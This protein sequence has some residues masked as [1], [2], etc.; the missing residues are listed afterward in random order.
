M[1]PES[2]RPAPDQ[3][4]ADGAERERPAADPPA[5]GRPVAPAPGARVRPGA[6]ARPGARTRPDA[7]AP[8][9]PRRRGPR[10]AFSLVA[11][12][13]LA[14]LAA[15]S[16]WA[17][18][19]LGAVDANDPRP[20]EFE[21]APGASAGRVAADLEAA[22]LLRDRRALLAVLRYRG[23]EGRIGEGLY[24]LRRDLTVPQI[25]D[26]LVRGG[27]PR[28]ARF[29]LPEGIRA[30]AV[31]RR[32]EAAGWTPDVVDG[33]AAIL[34]DPPPEWR[35]AGLPEGVGLEGYLFPAT[36]DLPLRM[37]AGEIVSAMLAR[38]QREVSGV[39][40]AELE[41]LEL[42][43][44][45]W[46]TLASMVQAEAGNDGEMG[47]IAGVFLNRLDLGMPLQSDPT[48]AY[49]L[50]KDLPELDRPAG[51]FETDHP[52]NTYTRPGLPVAPIGNPGAAALAAVLTPT[53]T[54]ES[55]RAWLYFLH[56][57]DGDAPVF[58]PNLDFD[59]HLRDVNRY[60]R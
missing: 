29:V 50:G 40:L 44:H 34:A 54:D 36:Y 27:R 22:G 56:G 60:L 53:R 16:A 9:P 26:A 42:D 38:F 57:V 32:I 6:R 23:D 31:V 48:V 59:E 58:R 1:S 13:A 35:P 12:L 25:A 43:L 37:D 20:V 18:W 33:V 28:T 17:L 46:V 5:I 14:L 55:G 11:L 39:V 47:I 4:A 30:N 3:P 15:A 2:D 49:G 41:R 7:P 51:D 10:A 45:A 21:I 8:I 19:S 52:W 24:D